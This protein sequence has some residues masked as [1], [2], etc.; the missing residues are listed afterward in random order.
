M[1]GHGAAI[2]RDSRRSFEAH[3]FGEWAYAAGGSVNEFKMGLIGVSTMR[4]DG[5]DNDDR[6]AVWQ[7]GNWTCPQTLRTEASRDC[8]QATRDAAGDWHEPEVQW[9]WRTSG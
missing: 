2:R 1:I 3:M 5:A 4:R 6:A 9:S 8:G 7:P